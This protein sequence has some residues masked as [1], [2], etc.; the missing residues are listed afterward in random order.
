MLNNLVC[1]GTLV[2]DVEIYTGK[3]QEPIAKLCVEIENE[4]GKDYFEAVAIHETAELANENL[5]KGD[6]IVIEGA[7]HNKYWKSKNGEN[8]VKTEIKIR[9]FSTLLHKGNDKCQEEK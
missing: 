6:T 9:K 8:R 7:I 1:I 3:K 4:N 5:K 2:R